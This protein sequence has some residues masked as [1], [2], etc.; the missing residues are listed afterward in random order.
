[1]GDM[2]VLMQI[3]GWSMSRIIESYWSIGLLMSFFIAV[4]WIA[5]MLRGPPR[6]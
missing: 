5:A 3:H 1:M 6:E 4:H 2:E